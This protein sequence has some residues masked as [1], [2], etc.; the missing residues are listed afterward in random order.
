MIDKRLYILIL[1][2]IAT[3]AVTYSTEVRTLKSF[4][5]RACG[6]NK[7]TPKDHNNILKETGP[8]PPKPDKKWCTVDANYKCKKENELNCP[9]GYVSVCGDVEYLG[10]HD[11]VNKHRKVKNKEECKEK[12]EKDPKC[13]GF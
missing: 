1:V 12:C 2:L 13:Q 11:G 8:K 3:S 4:F 6:K 10:K 7:K 9:E 5:R